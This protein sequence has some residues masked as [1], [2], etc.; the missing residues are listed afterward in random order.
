MN[1]IEN[2]EIEPHEYAQLNSDEGVLS[3]TGYTKINS[4]CNHGLNH[5]IKNINC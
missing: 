5:E 3:L 2:P 1:R 4:Q